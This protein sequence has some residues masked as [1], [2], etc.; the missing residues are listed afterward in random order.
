MAD[1][2]GPTEPSRPE[3]F[4]AFLADRGTRKPTAHTMKAYRQD[5]DAIAA[6]VA[7]RPLSV[8]T[9][10]AIVAAATD[11]TVIRSPIRSACSE[12]PHGRRIPCQQRVGTPT[13][14]GS[15]R[16]YAMIRCSAVATAHAVAMAATMPA[17]R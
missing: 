6:L 13:E 4:A 7:G 10:C 9:H 15:S 11:R 3:W 17:E 14:R 2:A 5:F 16:C 8:V 1:V 12:V